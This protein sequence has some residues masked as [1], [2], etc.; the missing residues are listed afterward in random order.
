M[1]I[2]S[3]KAWSSGFLSRTNIFV[4]IFTFP[5]VLFAGFLIVAPVLQSDGDLS[6]ALVMLSEEKAS[7]R[8]RYVS[9]PLGILITIGLLFVAIIL[10]KLGR[11]LGR[12]TKFGIFN[13]NNIIDIEPSYSGLEKKGA[14]TIK[15]KQ[16]S[17][18]L[19]GPYIE[20]FLNDQYVAGLMGDEGVRLILPP[21]DYQISL[22]LSSF[23]DSKQATNANLV[24]TKNGGP[25]REEIKQRKL[26]PTKTYR[27]SFPVS[28]KSE[29]EITYFCRINYGFRKL[30]D[31]SDQPISKV[32]KLAL[33]IKAWKSARN[34]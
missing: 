32:K 14:L 7:V 27:F 13:A 21:N 3:T 31:A 19:I 26:K 2:S 23:A 11:F 1:L 12:N 28:V 5:L 18:R 29:E 30:L 25:L 16:G 8:G 20:I 9:S 33:V 34:T 22:R 17:A 24:L 6:K 10:M 4:C 15:G